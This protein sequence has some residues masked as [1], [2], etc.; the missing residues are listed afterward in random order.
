MF[1]RLALIA[2]TGLL[3]A[4]V[5]VLPEPKAPEGLY[6]FGP[7]EASYEL[8]AS[9]LVREP[10]ASRLFAGRAI[11]AEGEDGAMRL[12]KG[13]RWSDNA[14]RM[15]QTALLDTFDG[16]DGAVAMAS[17]TGAVA[18]YE[19]AWRISDFTLAGGKARCRLEATLLDGRSRKIVDQT[20]VATEAVAVNKTNAARANALTDA[21]R[22][23]I[24][25]VAGFVAGQTT[26]EN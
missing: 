2:T 12:L 22:A 16:T 1:R 10:D 7:M 8:E 24:N 20:I 14:T 5:S 17:G 3:A 18:D 21:G 15:M 4:C 19:L 26:Q 9:V 6:R 11:A 25:E 13:V 23:C